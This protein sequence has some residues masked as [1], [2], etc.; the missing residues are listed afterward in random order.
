MGANSV[1]GYTY[2]GA[3]RKW[4]NDVTGRTVGAKPLPSIEPS[5]SKR[6]TVTQSRA[7]A[8]APAA[9]LANLVAG[10]K[11]Q[12]RQPVT[13]G[14]EKD[15]QQQRARAH[16]QLAEQNGQTQ[17]PN[18]FLPNTLPRSQGPN[19]SD[20]TANLTNTISSALSQ[21]KGLTDVYALMNQK[22]Q[23]AS[24]LPKVGYQN[25]NST[26][27]PGKAPV[28][29]PRNTSYNWLGDFAGALGGQKGY[30]AST[31]K[32][33]LAL[34]GRSVEL[35]HGST[36]AI[37]DGQEVNLG[38]PV[39]FS[40]GKAYVPDRALAEAL[41]AK[42]DWSPG[43]VSITGQ[44]SPDKY[45]AEAQRQYDEV[46]VP[47]INA[48]LDQLEANSR[49]YE[50]FMG[51]LGLNYEHNVKNVEDGFN[52]TMDYLK[53]M[54]LK[55]ADSLTE[56]LNNAG[57]LSST[58]GAGALGKLHET[59][60]KEYAKAGRS[61]ASAIDELNLAESQQKKSMLRELLS[62]ITSGTRDIYNKIGGRA[63]AIQSAADTAKAAAAKEAADRAA[64]EWEHQLDLNKYSLDVSRY[65]TDT[66][67]KNKQYGLNLQKLNLQTNLDW[68]KLN[69][70]KM[71]YNLDVAK[72][73]YS[74]DAKRAKT[75]ASQDYNHYMAIYTDNMLHAAN[76]QRKGVTA[77]DPLAWLV[78]NSG[79]IIRRVGD[80]GY[81][82]LQA[83]L[84]KSLNMM[85]N[86][87]REEAQ[88]LEL[89]LKRQNVTKNKEMGYK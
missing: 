85:P 76:P 44:I 17:Q 63:G 54:E 27:N 15:W 48:T 51:E 13:Y 83:S 64:D 47:Q 22:R 9:N 8:P 26:L 53:E 16:Q 19:L 71:R 46:L 23:E 82:A 24:N 18:T 56:T 39:I 28:G 42:V 49:A 65:N 30:D 79:A 73:Q 58:A 11:T 55:G 62:G 21:G 72:A 87:L 69:L 60:G 2:N 68:S 66:E 61:K 81:R 77:I 35:K 40:G 43:Q 78:N 84:A 5:L 75:R 12:V 57:M 74:L 20:F 7:P 89:H 37:I 52:Q 36:T 67:L 6:R 4:K 41:G 31:G 32:A 14:I 86:K 34:N 25:V 38:A 70:D 1:Y 45:T 10:A 29:A 3:T 88:K 80:K 50:D 33:T 59:Y